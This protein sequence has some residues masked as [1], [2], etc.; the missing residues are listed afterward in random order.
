MRS[1]CNRFCLAAL[2]LALVGCHGPG[3]GHSSEAQHGHG[4]EVG[5]SAGEPPSG[6][7]GL[8]LNG[9]EKWQMDDHTRSM[10]TQMVQRLEGSDL[11]SATVTELKES[12]SLLRKDIDELIA[13][14]TMEGEAH[15]VLHKYLVAYIPS[16]DALSKSG[17]SESA[18]AVQALLQ[19][20]PR[21]FE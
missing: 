4:H 19:V 10:F 16:V 18:E 17:D 11:E 15:D 13:G 12:G 20:Y 7:H 5:E 2:T 1:H 9:A 14:C 21:F 8:V 3:E 6:S